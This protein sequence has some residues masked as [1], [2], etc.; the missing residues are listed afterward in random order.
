VYKNK[1]L[2][3]PEFA[4]LTSSKRFK[5]FI[6]CKIQVFLFLFLCSETLTVIAVLLLADVTLFIRTLFRS[7]ELSQ[8]FGG[9]L[10]NSQVQ[11]MVLDGCMVIIACS[12][13]TFMHP[14]YAFQKRWND[15]KFPFFYNH[16]QTPARSP[17]PPVPVQQG[18]E[19]PDA[20]E[21]TDTIEGKQ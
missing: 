5:W 1:D 10:A 4:E 15:A 21:L 11:F 14:G 3:N 2:R 19:S 8:G 18:S 17:K 20:V 9:K 12:C 7:V 6:R 13:M 16:F